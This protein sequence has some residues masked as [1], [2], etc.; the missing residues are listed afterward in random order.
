MFEYIRKFWPSGKKRKEEFINKLKDPN[1]GKTKIQFKD[2]T[3]L[4]IGT[5]ISVNDYRTG[6]HTCLIY[7]KINT[8]RVY[9]NKKKS[10]QMTNTSVENFLTTLQNQV[11]KN[12]NLP[13]YKE[14]K[15]I[16]Y[17]ST[18]C[19]NLDYSAFDKMNS[20]FYKNT[21]V[22]NTNNT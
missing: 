13:Y 11:N 7:T 6:I 2:Q 16:I 8:W 9:D 21:N 20:G 10:K 22:K 3:N 18:K 15:I 17:D 14:D 12:D 1:Y 5:F 19:L 4:V